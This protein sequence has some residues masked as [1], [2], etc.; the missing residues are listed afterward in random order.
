M[1]WLATLKN[2][3][4]TIKSRSPK[5]ICLCGDFNIAPEDCDIHNPKGKEVHIMASPQER[6]ALQ[7]IL[8]LG[9]SDV[10]RHF[11]P[12]GGHFSWWDYRQGGFQRNRGWRI[13]HHYLTPPLIDRAIACQIDI[14]PRKLPQ[15]SDH[16]PVILAIKRE[17]ERSQG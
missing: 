15:P 11:T 5:A 7:E 2:Y 12:D 6:K 14:E 9:L 13:D 16:T 10:F 3:L 17:R 1:R 8:D 4:E